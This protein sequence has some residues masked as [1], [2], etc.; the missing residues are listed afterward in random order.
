MKK[1]WLFL[2]FV[3]VAFIAVLY[4]NGG[5]SK[6]SERKPEPITESQGEE[7]NQ[8]TDSEE[9]IP[10]VQDNSH[11]SG[12]E[13]PSYNKKIPIIF[14]L[15]YAF[16]YAEKHEQAYWVAYE[17]T[18]KETEKVYN[19]TDKFIP[20]PYVKTGSATQQDYAGSGFD[21]GHLAPAADMG[22]SSKAM[23]ESFYFSNMSP[24]AP[25]FNRG[26]W[27]RLEEQV[28]SWAIA[29]DQV[30]VV[31]GPVLKNGLR[32]IGPNQVS[33]P[34]YYYKVILDD[35]GKD[36]KAIGFIMANTKGGGS[37]ASYAVSV[38]QV[39]K[40]TGIDFFHKLPDQIEQKMEKDACLSCWE[41]KITKPK[42][43]TSRK[44]TV[45]VQ[46]H[47]ITKAGARCKRSC[48]DGSSY[49]YQHKP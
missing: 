47:G 18:K 10:A 25:S 45:K 32:T 5:Q 42:S 29:Y 26:I 33:I 22:W 13:I 20:D 49:C 1:G 48:S 37:L 12:L 14:H 7:N 30:Y 41:W 46:C 34:D 28:R 2:G 44:Q 6:P 27:K 43:S 11:V 21:R 9:E 3:L 8:I 24:Q 17:L 16:Q 40:E 19:R 23:Q 38:D 31:T 39:E 36:K 35:T 15:G 4:L